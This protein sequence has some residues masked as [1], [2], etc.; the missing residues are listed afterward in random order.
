M[1]NRYLVLIL[2]VTLFVVASLVYA[3]PKSGLSQLEFDRGVPSDD[4]AANVKTMLD[5]ASGLSDE[6]REALEE[7]H[8]IMKGS[9][10]TEGS[11]I[12]SGDAKASR[13]GNTGNP[14]SDKKPLS[15]KSITVEEKTI[16]LPEE[17]SF[18]PPSLK[19]PK[20]DKDNANQ[21][22][23]VSAWQPANGSCVT[24]VSTAQL[25]DKSRALSEMIDRYTGTQGLLDA[26]ISQQK[27]SV[28]DQVCVLTDVS[29]VSGGAVTISPIADGDACKMRLK[30]ER[31][32][33]TWQ[34]VKLQALRCSCVPKDCSAGGA[35]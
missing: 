17:E 13:E 23:S 28:A 27:C 24:Y 9:K 25:C 12:S 6:D 4:S 33:G 22:T 18:L 14:S 8:S 31:S 32:A 7:L 16:T 2:P 19:G 3:E 29:A 30:R 10:D 34:V 5:N 15:G 21:V 1:K 26:E 11:G 20:T 35:Q